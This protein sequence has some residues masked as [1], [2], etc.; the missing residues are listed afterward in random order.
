[1]SKPTRKGEGHRLFA[2]ASGASK[3][4]IQQQSFSFMGH[5]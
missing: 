1:M 2:E 3:Q 5:P 4:S